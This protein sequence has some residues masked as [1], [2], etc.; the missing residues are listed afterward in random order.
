MLLF[1]A[2]SSTNTNEKDTAYGILN[3]PQEGL[4]SLLP[5]PASTNGKVYYNNDQKLM[6][7][8]ADF[9][10][11]DFEAYIEECKSLG[12]DQ[13]IWNSTSRYSAQNKTGESLVISLDEDSNVA[14]LDVYTSS[15]F[16]TAK[17]ETAD[18]E[19]NL[20]SFD[21][22]DPQTPAKKEASAFKKKMNEIEDFFVDYT[23]F[24]L[25]YYSNEDILP[26]SKNNI[27]TYM[28]YHSECKEMVARLDEMKESAL[29]EEEEK[30]YQDALCRINRLYEMC[31]RYEKGV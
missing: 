15:D 31:A 18:S 29:S 11:E 6:V 10:I 16:S 4:A 23:N 1:S 2:C 7:Y 26:L 3:W 21:E 27:V 12:F 30:I 14:R 24:I 13:N 5:E 19:E 17:T 28:S 8:L 25:G 20:L 22:E 9:S